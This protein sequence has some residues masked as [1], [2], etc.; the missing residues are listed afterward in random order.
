MLLVCIDHL[1]Q[2]KSMLLIVIRGVN[3]DIKK[4]RGKLSSSDAQ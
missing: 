2:V 4:V 1:V 3:S